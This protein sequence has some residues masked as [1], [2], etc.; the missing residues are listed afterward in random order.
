MKHKCVLQMSVLLILTLVAVVAGH[1]GTE[2]FED[3]PLPPPLP[4]SYADRQRTTYAYQTGAMPGWKHFGAPVGFWHTF[5]GP[6]LDLYYPVRFPRYPGFYDQ[7]AVIYQSQP[8]PLPYGSYLPEVPA[9]PA[10][11]EMSWVLR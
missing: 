9:S 2:P 10:G 5:S 11:A 1:V 4:G 8:F 6:S 7:R 3:Y